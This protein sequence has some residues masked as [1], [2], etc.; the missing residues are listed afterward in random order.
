[1]KKILVFLIL[2][3]FLSSQAA[4]AWEKNLVKSN[5]LRA[6]AFT[7]R[8]KPD[9]GRPFYL[10]SGKALASYAKRKVEALKSL[11]VGPIVLTIADDPMPGEIGHIRIAFYKPPARG[12]VPGTSSGHIMLYFDIK[13]VQEKASGGNGKLVN[14]THVEYGVKPPKGSTFSR[15]AILRTTPGFTLSDMADSYFDS[16]LSQYIPEDWLADA[17][18]RQILTAI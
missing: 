7:D 14:S 11:G 17:V 4:F 3:I 13:L 16:F 6:K 1:V 8:K 10:S 2:S 9:E 15:S 12:E 5:S 18:A